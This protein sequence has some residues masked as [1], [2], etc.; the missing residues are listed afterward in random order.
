RLEGG[1]LGRVDD[2]V[3]VQGINVFPSAIE[4]VMRELPEIDEFRIEA[5]QRRALTEL[6]LTLEPGPECTSTTG[7]AGR[8]AQKLRE[9]LSLRPEVD[10][11]SPGTLVSVRRKAK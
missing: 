7:L 10:R 11:V 2:M 8:V 5:V 1:V 9:S 3:V 4:N 6:R